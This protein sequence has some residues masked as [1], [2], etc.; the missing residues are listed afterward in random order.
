MRGTRQGGA[1]LKLVG[2]GRM[3]TL[4]LALALGSGRA[5]AT[6]YDNIN[7][8][9]PIEDEI[10]I[11]D[12]YDSRLLHNRIRL[13]HLDTRPHQLIELQ[14][15]GAPPVSPGRVLEIS[16]ARIERRLGRDRSPLFAPHPRYEATPRLFESS[17]E[18]TRFE[19]SMGAEGVLENDGGSG[20]V[21]SGSGVQ[22]RLALGL[23]RLL[24]YSH[25]SVGHVD[26]ARRFGDPI[27]PNNDLIV[28]TD[29]SFISYTEEQGAWGIQFGLQRLHW[30]PG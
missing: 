11:L 3:L 24:A 22:G 26:N 12:Y 2:V 29:E 4:A 15:I 8:V 16:L 20:H 19:V 7:V 27:I 17:L 21:V 30:G 23:D 14:G 28:T 6:P 13:P 1:R 18:K 9:D 10:R 25:Y 5:A